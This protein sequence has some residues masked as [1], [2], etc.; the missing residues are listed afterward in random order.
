MALAGQCRRVEASS[1]THPG[2]QADAFVGPATSVNVDTGG[3]FRRPSDQATTCRAANCEM[4]VFAE[5][6]S[7]CHSATLTRL[8]ATAVMT[9][10]KR[11]F[12]NPM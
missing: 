11:V 10:C 4:R 12:A 3:E 2:R 8:T 9:R 7:L 6:V 1:A 5:R